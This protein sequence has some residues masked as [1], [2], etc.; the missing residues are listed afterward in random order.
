M[1][2]QQLALAVGLDDY[3]R[4]ETFFAGPNE[5]VVSHLHGFALARE[6]HPASWLRGAPGSGKTHLLQASCAA[7]AGNG[8]LTRF[9]PL[10]S[11]ADLDPAILEIQPGL[12]LLCLDD[13]DAVAGQPAWEGAVFR[14]FNEVTGDGGSV[15]VAASGGP[16]ETDFTLADLRS[17]LSWGPTYR[18]EPLTDPERVAALRL[19]ARHRGFEL[20]DDVGE[21]LLKRVPRDMPSLYRLLDKLDAASL[22]AGRRIT[23]PFVRDI[24]NSAGTPGT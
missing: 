1:K 15:L 7:A 2:E 4:F 9:V 10:A 24:L 5:Q 11:F 19:R 6:D 13:I 18:L 21:W 23:I 20:G 14:A 22:Q 17:R 16:R 3:A 12:G 8:L